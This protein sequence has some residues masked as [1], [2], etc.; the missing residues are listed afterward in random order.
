[1]ARLNASLIVIVC[2]FC[3]GAVNASVDQVDQYGMQLKERDAQSGAQS[4]S[5][6]CA[7]I[8]STFPTLSRYVAGSQYGCCGNKW[9]TC[10]PDGYVTNLYSNE[11][12]D[13]SITTIP[14]SIQKLSKI[15]VLQL[16]NAGFTG[17]IPT[18]L[19]NMI[20][21]QTLILDHN[22]FSGI[23]PDCI[24]NLKN[25]KSLSIAFNNLEGPISGSLGSLPLLGYLALNS[26]GFIGEIPPALG[27][28]SNLAFFF[29]VTL[30]TKIRDYNIRI[31]IFLRD[32][33]GNYLVGDITSLFADNSFAMLNYLNLAENCLTGTLPAYLSSAGELGPQY[34]DCSLSAATE[35]LL[36]VPAT[37]TY[38]PVYTATDIPDLTV[39]ATGVSASTAV[40]TPIVTS[41]P[42]YVAGSPDCA[43]VLS[44]FP[45]L[46]AMLY[47]FPFGCCDGNMVK[48][49]GSGS[50]TSI[51]STG[52]IDPT[53]PNVTLS[54]SLQ[55]LYQLSTLVVSKAGLSGGIPIVVCT[56]QTLQTLVLDD[57]AFTTI[58]DCIG[59][60]LYSLSILSIRRNN[61]VGN[62]PSSFSSLKS[63]LEINLEGNA[64]SGGL[65][66]LTNTQS[67]AKIYLG[68]NQLGGN[69]PS[70][71]NLRSLTTLDL[72][73][74]SLVGAIDPIGGIS[75]SL[76]Y[77]DLSSNYFT[78]SVTDLFFNHQFYSLAYFNV[79]NN[80]L[81]GQ[82]AYYLMTAGF[83]LGPQYTDCSI[84]YS[85]TTKPATTTPTPLAQSS[86]SMAPTTGYYVVTPITTNNSTS[87]N[88]TSTSSKPTLTP[89][90][91]TAVYGIPT[92]TVSH[93]IIFSSQ[94]INSNSWLKATYDIKTNFD[95]SESNDNS[96]L[97][98]TDSYFKYAFPEV[99][100]ITYGF[101][102]GCC[103][104]GLVQ[105]TADGFV[106]SIY[107][108]G[109]IDSQ[110][111]VTSIP[112]AIQ[113]L[114]K[115]NSL[116]IVSG[117]LKGELPSWLFSMINLQTLAFPYNSIS[118]S[119]SESFANLRN[120]SY[121]DIS[122]NQL[123]GVIPNAF[124]N[125][126][127]L[128]YIFTFG[129]QKDS[130]IVPT[131]TIATPTAT[132]TPTNIPAQNSDCGIILASFP[133]LANT[134]AGSAFGCCD[135]AWIQCTADGFVT[136]I[137]SMG[138]IDTSKSVVSIPRGVQNLTQLATLQIINAGLS[139]EIPSW[140]CNVTT[141]QRPDVQ[142]FQWL[143]PA[144]NWEHD[145]SRIPWG[146]GMVITLSNNSLTGG[147]SALS[148]IPSLTELYASN[149]QFGGS[150]SPFTIQKSLI[151]LDIHNNQFT[152]DASII[153][154]LPTTLKSLDIS[155]NHFYGSIG[156]AFANSQF[157]DLTK[158]N[159]ANNCFTGDLPLY[160]STFTLGA[161]RQNCSIASGTTTPTS[162]LTNQMQTKSDGFSTIYEDKS[163]LVRLFITL[164][165]IMLA[166]SI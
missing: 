156:D 91:T 150:M 32:V 11:P 155:S 89:Q 1:M 73:N 40:Y 76:K 48:C 31:R 80:C 102:F 95:A 75:W 137:N 71:D 25:L 145:K 127:K 113:Q 19:C 63:L 67:L 101:P 66:T 41:T 13:Y 97:W 130:C 10:T 125:L 157:Y 49:T 126:S 138:P 5:A 132:P 50:V 58:P 164:G 105:C 146:A 24:A 90:N 133:A 43:V 35:T 124:G 141:L 153:S 26:N 149:N 134:I 118:G 154:N 158:L 82:L 42:V 121:L 39:S 3:W 122:F 106:T 2:C 47:K 88:R 136:F 152:G 51:N 114:A 96:S 151:V 123:S 128:E 98:R 79:S 14:T 52:P 108:Y 162:N 72:H 143:N 37:D 142:Q 27:A 44:S 20:T 28:L 34:A 69:L 93:M 159:L 23:L 104:G 87:I 55:T 120:L 54:G 64:L 15:S 165:V 33:S 111:F 62:I 163:M 86:N 147:I 12:L 115:L 81:T 109:P 53:N 116:Q 144:I 140:L 21:L 6:D 36:N 30:G 70:L 78:G 99:A 166:F 119:L 68:N 139:G 45:N 29:E 92:S 160:L 9:I 56:L 4:I 16:S 161:Q 112:P 135:G 17:G 18:W 110:N 131:P 83:T 65:A 8:L 94:V 148:N 57:N 46:A 7:T 84:V 100:R 107:S 60:K 77:C 38:I 117:N 85:T 103:D 129:P 61:L 22:S 59:S 74:N